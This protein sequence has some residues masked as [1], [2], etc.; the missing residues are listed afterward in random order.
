MANEVSAVAEEWSSDD[1]RP[2]VLGEGY[3]PAATRVLGAGIE[4]F[5]RIGFLAT[6]VRDLTKLCGITAPSFYNHFGSK[7][8]LLHDIV[9][10]ADAELESRLDA[11]DVDGLDPVEALSGLV[12]TLVIFN[13]TY[14]REARIANREWVFL[15][16]EDHT[17]VLAHRRR[18]RALF[19]RV[20]D[21]A[22]TKRGLLG[23]DKPSTA[24]HL[25]TRL[26]AMSIINMGIDSS[27]WYRPD[28]PLTIEEVADSY[29]RLAQRMAGISS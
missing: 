7:E 12:R 3:T 6:T 10:A 26:L 22:P 25:E 11:I 29:C 21:A 2:T 5:A 27:D 20:L 18:V 19:E 13:L 8:G 28:G 4:L 23:G 16:A 24:A 15:Q 17:D 9:E 14:P 1:S